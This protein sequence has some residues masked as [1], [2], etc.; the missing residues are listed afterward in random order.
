MKKRVYHLLAVTIM[1]GLAGIWSG[2]KDAP[3]PSLW[4]PN[5]GSG[6]QPVL[7]SLSP[8]DSG[9]AGISRIVITGQNFSTN[10][11]DNLV[12][13][14]AVLA[15][16]LQASATQLTVLAP[17]TPKDSIEIKIAVTGADKFSDPVFYGLVSAAPTFGNFGVADQP[18]GVECDAAGNVYVSVTSSGSGIGVLKYAPD[19][20]K[21]TYSPV[22]SPSVSNWRGMKFGAGGVL[23]CVTGRP[24]IFQIPNGGGAATVWVSSGL[25]ALNDLDFDQSGNIWSAGPG[26]KIYRIKSDKTVKS[27]PFVGTVRAVRVYNGYLYVGGLRD[28]LEQVWRFPIDGSG[29]LGA[30]EVYF[31]LSFIY[32][33]NSFG[34]YAITFAADGD[35]LLGTDG[36]DAIFLVHPNGTSEPLYP[37]VLQPTTFSFTWGSGPTIFVSRQSATIA[38]TLVKI[39]TQ[40]TS[41]PYYGRLL[42]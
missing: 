25:T 20:T 28:S 26:T 14:D 15:N 18:F 17:N 24:I 1:A 37:G 13:F 39:N 19:G 35:M 9:L 38:Q 3:P 4:D 5:A 42:P 41:A 16:V 36:P 30:E 40:K 22:F 29:D 34:V 11:P 32:G 31:N 21:T 6:P 8:A 23:Y 2:C 33:A 27:Y 7:T 10:P 12:F